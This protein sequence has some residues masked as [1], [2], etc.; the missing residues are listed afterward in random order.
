MQKCHALN[1]QLRAHLTFTLSHYTVSKTWIKANLDNVVTGKVRRWLDLPPNATAHFIPLP[2]KWLGLDLVL[3]SMLSEVCQLNTTLALHHSSDPRMAVLNR[4]TNDRVP[5]CEQLAAA[6]K[7]NAMDAAKNTQL[8]RHLEQ[9]DSLRVQSILHIALRS[10]LTATELTNWSTHLALISP[11]ISNF[12]RK[13][14]IRCLPTNSN[15]NRW[16]KVPTDTCPQ[17]SNMETENHVL[18]NCPVSAQQG[19]YTWRHNAVLRILATHIQAHISPESDLFIDIPGLNN[20]QDLY[21]SIIPDITVLRGSRAV[22]LELT[23][24]Y[25]KNIEKSRLYKLDKY[26]DPTE[27]SKRELTFTVYTTEVSSLGF[28][29]SA[30]LSRFCADVAIPPFPSDTLRKMGEM[31]LRCSYYIFCCRHK[32]WPTS[33]TEPYFH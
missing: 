3:P 8:N 15:L 31:S 14:L 1:L 22:I 12:A 28:I 27:S 32:P 4:L 23:C 6:S 13:A 9:M 7:K 21:T 10:A 29:P 5:F 30:S 26:K 17:C 16:G 19:R 11:N 33:P 24:C 18:N 25:E 2:H 20:P